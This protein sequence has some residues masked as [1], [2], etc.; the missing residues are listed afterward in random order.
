MY[1]DSNTGTPGRNRTYGQKLRSLLLYPL[2]YR[3]ATSI[4]TNTAP[5]GRPNL[6]KFHFGAGAENRTPILSLE[7][8]HTNR[9]TT[10]ANGYI[11]A[12]LRHV[13]NRVVQTHHPIDTLRRVIVRFSVAQN[14]SGVRPFRLLCGRW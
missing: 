1:S 2:S 8:L 7:N 12:F 4:I 6:R 10:P 13:I 14:S 9:C 5:R 11:V 3:G